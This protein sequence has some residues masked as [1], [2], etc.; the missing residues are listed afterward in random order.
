MPPLDYIINISSDEEDDIGE[1]DVE[2]VEFR[3]VTNDLIDHPSQ[4]PNH[5]T[6]KLSDVQCPIC[7]D[8]VTN[9]TTTSCGHIFCLECIEQSISSSHARGQVSGNGRGK[10]LCPLCRKQVSFKDTILIR[11]KVGERIGKPELPPKEPK[12]DE[13]K[14]TDIKLD[15]PSPKKRKKE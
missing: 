11:L 3:K 9:A 12:K 10:G 14:V 5:T 13:I 8:D 2:I 1:E 4:K 7:F 15:E 6:K